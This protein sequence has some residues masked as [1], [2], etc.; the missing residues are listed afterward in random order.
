MTCTDIAAVLSIQLI[1]SSKAINSV[2]ELPNSDIITGSDDQF[3]TYFQRSSGAYNKVSAYKLEKIPHCLAFDTKNHHVYAACAGGKVE[4]LAIQN[5]QLALLTSFTWS[6]RELSSIIFKF[7]SDLIFCA[8]FDGKLFVYDT[9][10]QKLINS[11]QL[12]DKPIRT[13]TYDDVGGKLYLGTHGKGI[14]VYDCKDPRVDIPTLVFVLGDPD[15]V[16]LSHIDPVRAVFMDYR[17]RYIF[18]CDHSG[19]ILVWHAGTSGQEK[20]SKALGELKYDNKKI[21]SVV[22]VP[23]KR[24]LFQASETGFITGWNPGVKR[25]IG[26]FQAHGNE[27][28]GIFVMNS[29]DVC[30]F[31]KDGRVCIWSVQYKQE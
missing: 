28:M 3:L 8:G 1:A 23:E 16:N 12:S 2:I 25:S 4:I 6:K 17:S 20:I 15:T 22:W 11:Y 31:G 7:E 24:V 26:T 9:I 5:G 13:I 21:R 19:K 30:S 27:I 14:P 10:A 29:G 18:S